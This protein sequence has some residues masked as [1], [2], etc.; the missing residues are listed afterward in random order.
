M[1]IAAAKSSTR[2]SSGAVRS[3]VT[4]TSH[5]PTPR[6]KA[7]ARSRIAAG[8][9]GTSVR[10]AR[11]SPRQASRAP[12]LA[13][14]SGQQ[15]DFVHMLLTREQAEAILAGPTDPIAVLDEIGRLALLVNKAEVEAYAEA[16]GMKPTLATA[17]S[18]AR[19]RRRLDDGA[20]GRRHL[21]SLLPNGPARHR[22]LDR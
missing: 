2:P 20:A 16:G 4:F 1:L 10:I 8:N 9:G 7:G 18:P 11:A 17:A 21:P 19:L 6:R 22:G 15:S 5:G 14:T 12:G 3:R 13:G